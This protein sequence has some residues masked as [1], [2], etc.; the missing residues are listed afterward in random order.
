MPEPGRPPKGGTVYLATADRDGMMVS[1]IQSGYDDFGSGIV[2]PG[3]GISLQN[4]GSCFSLERGHPNE[5]APAKRPRH[6]ILPAFLTRDGRA[7]GP[8]GV[9]GGEMQPQ[10]HLQVIGHLLDHGLDPQ[11]ALDAPRWRVTGG[12]GVSVE[13]GF[14]PSVLDALVARGHALTRDCPFD[15]FGRGQV[16]VRH[17]SGVYEAGSEPRADGAAVGY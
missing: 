11:A 3:T 15:D 9:M 1:F 4:R 14:D 6:T 16:I 10:G 7:I 5:A 13:S 17:E 8:F 2:V 12:L